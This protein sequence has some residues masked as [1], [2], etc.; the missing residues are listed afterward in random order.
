MEQRFAFVLR[1]WLTES[2]PRAGR[3][4][5]S[6]RG[7]LQAVNSAELLH[8]TSLRQLND[9]IETALHPNDSS[10]D[11]SSTDDSSTTNSMSTDRP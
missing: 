11:G 3:K 8:F 2:L 9:L 10:T 5:D 6:L 1:I 4:A 7:T